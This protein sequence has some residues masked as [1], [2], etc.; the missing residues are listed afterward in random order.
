MTTPISLL[1]TVRPNPDVLVRSV[2]DSVVLLH[3]GSEHYFS[4][5]DV[6]AA[7]WDALGAGGPLAAAVPGL[8]SRFDVDASVLEGDLV[9]LA[10]E[11]LDAGLLEHC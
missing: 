3:L 6:G 9:R 4:L 10:Q 7:M 11:L 5:D 2:G 8:L 1:S